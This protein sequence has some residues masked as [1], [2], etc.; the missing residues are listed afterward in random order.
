ETVGEAEAARAA[1]GGVEAAFLA[2]HP[3]AAAI[4][5]ATIVVADHPIVLRIAPPVAPED[6]VLSNSGLDRRIELLG[7]VPERLHALGIVE[8]LAERHLVGGDPED[9]AVE[10]LVARAQQVALVVGPADLGD[11]ARP[12]PPDSLQRDVV[13]GD[14]GDPRR[15][16]P[17]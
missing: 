3:V 7:D 11:V 14:P 2:A 17:R 8:V 16:V 1:R 5:A 15:P 6:A 12:R 10:K 13:D 9:L 4:M